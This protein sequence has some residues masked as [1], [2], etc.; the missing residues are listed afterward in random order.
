MTMALVVVVVFVAALAQSLSGFGFALMV[1][2]LLTIAMGLRTA[3]PLVALVGLTLYTVNIV[4]Y[5]RAINFGEVLRLGAASAAG[6]P[7]GIWALAN[8]D[9][10]VI[11]PLLGVTLIAY[12]IYALMSP[13]TSRRCSHRWVY[14]AGFLA[15]CLGGAYNTPGPP[16]VVYGS[17]R[18]WPKEKF[19]AVL[20]VLFFLNAVLIVASHC[21]AHHLTATVL[22]SYACAVPALLSGVLA[23][24]YVDRRVNRERFHTIVGAMT[25]I[26]GLSLCLGLG[27]H[28]GR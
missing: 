25:L 19:R 20:Q 2:P 26:L 4:R 23:G 24:S 15:G 1:M 13:A 18:G 10:A 17:L 12:A 21:V 7:I 14:P 9:E 11:K 22:R 5:R 6:I 3:A 27:R 8:V 16:V 28:W